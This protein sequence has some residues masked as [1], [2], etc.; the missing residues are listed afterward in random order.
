MPENG[1]IPAP[2][3]PLPV[4]AIEAVVVTD[5]S[6]AALVSLVLGERSLPIRLA[7]G[8]VPPLVSALIV[9]YRHAQGAPL[10][11][12]G[13]G[14]MDGPVEGQA[15]KSA[16][17]VRWTVAARSDGAGVEIAFVEAGSCTAVT[18]DAGEARALAQAILT[19]VHGR[20]PVE[21]SLCF[22]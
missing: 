20:I 17:E 16:G 3:A 12:E 6:D 18:L 11:G 7:V 1:P 4:D 21:A 13:A 8:M 19:A 2:P 9:A 15:E 5:D 10:D 22:Q 14:R